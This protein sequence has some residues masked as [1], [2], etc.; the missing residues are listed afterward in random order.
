MPQASGG[1]TRSTACRRPTASCADRLKFVPG[2]C[3]TASPDADIARGG[4]GFPPRL[5]GSVD[6]NAALGA[7]RVGG[8]RHEHVLGLG[9]GRDR[10]C[11]FRG[12]HVLEPLVGLGI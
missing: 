10:M 3:A 12:R 9:I 2:L 5:L 1:S 7:V 6:S 8:E 4:T 11:A